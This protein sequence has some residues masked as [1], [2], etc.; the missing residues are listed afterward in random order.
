[1]NLI[2]VLIVILGIGII[3]GFGLPAYKNWIEEHK[4]MNDAVEDAHYSFYESSCTARD[5]VYN[6]EY[7]VCI[8]AEGVMYNPVVDGGGL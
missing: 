5:M 7:G 2:E 4:A 6:F 1:M 8:D 3:G